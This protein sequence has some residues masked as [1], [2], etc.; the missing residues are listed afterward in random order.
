MFEPLQ[1]RLTAPLHGNRIE[2]PLPVQDAIRQCLLVCQGLE[3][4]LL[5]R[6]PRDQVDDRDA[7]GLVLP[8]GPRD[9]L[10]QLRRIPGQV[11]VDDDAG[12]LKVEPGAAAV[13]AQEHAAV[14]VR[15]ER[16]DLRTSPPLGHRARVPGKPESDPAANLPHQFQHPFPFT[17][18]D[19]LDPGL[20]RHSSR[21]FSNSDS[22]A[23]DRSSGWRM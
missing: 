23:H 13:G 20:S 3:H 8:P 22:L 4:A 6:P 5:Q 11:A 21:I 1:E 14:R 15:L 17:E 12:I 16:V 10:L 7:L 2:I 19:H 9:A 18:D